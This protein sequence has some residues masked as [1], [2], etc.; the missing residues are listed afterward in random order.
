ML[1]IWDSATEHHMSSIM[2]A[3]K[4]NVVCVKAVAD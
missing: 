1:W 4:L 3:E 2:F